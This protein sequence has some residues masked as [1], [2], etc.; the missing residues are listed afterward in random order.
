MVD[1]VNEPTL[2]ELTGRWD[3]SAL[4][5]NVRLGSGV[6]LE[7]KDSF[8]RFRSEQDPG[9]VLGREVIAYSWTDF[10]VDPTGVLEIG[11]RTVLVGAVFMCAEHIVVGPDVVIS[12]GVTVADCDF[13]PID[14]ELRRRDA[15][16]VAPG[17][18]ESMRIPLSTAP[19]VIER[20]VRIGIGA[21]VLKG[22]TIGEGAQIE[23]GAVVTRSVAAGVRVRG[24]PAGVVDPA[25]A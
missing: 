8:R 2:D 19:V 1:A 14:P 11:D 21:I 25:G 5:T 23:P 22:V 13:H 3:Y 18:H 24:N 10:S 17:G 4:P 6:F 15:M 7:R 16:A 20:G 12:Y 9:L